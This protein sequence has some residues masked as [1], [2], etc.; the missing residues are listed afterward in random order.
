MQANK[1]TLLTHH[2]ASPWAQPERLG[3]VESR[4]EK[5]KEA[6][7]SSAGSHQGG[8]W[9]CLDRFW[10]SLQS[11]PDQSETRGCPERRVLPGARGKSK[12]EVTADWRR[13][14]NWGCTD[15][16]SSKMA[17]E[18][19]IEARTEERHTMCELWISLEIP[20]DSS[21][22]KGTAFCRVLSEQDGGNT[23]IHV[24]ISLTVQDM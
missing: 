14:E 10:S 7:P 3:A 24:S 5:H 4:A 23:R 1:L 8:A 22:A 19:V 13:R 20:K 11:L 18:Q 9:K 21:E 16:K 15:S 2:I 12:W 6:S 17:R